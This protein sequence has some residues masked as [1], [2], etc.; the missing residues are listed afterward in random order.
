MEGNII[1]FYYNYKELENIAKANKKFI[2]HANRYLSLINSLGENMRH[3]CKICGRAI[4]PDSPEMTCWV[5]YNKKLGNDE[6]I[7]KEAHA[8]AAR[9]RKTAKIIEQK[10]IEVAARKWE[11]NLAEYESE[12]KKELEVLERD[13]KKVALKFFNDNKLYSE[14]ILLLMEPSL[15]ELHKGISR[16]KLCTLLGISPYDCK[17]F[18]MKLIMDGK[19][20]KIRRFYK[21]SI[22]YLK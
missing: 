13:M 5:C 9:K 10:R 1:T 14:K 3:K 19:A 11:K 17:V 4:G 16:P 8:E 22:Y 20:Y 21:N 2:S 12:R 18:L 15:T 6:A 7:Q